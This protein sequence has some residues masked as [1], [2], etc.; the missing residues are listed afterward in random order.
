MYGYWGSPSEG[1]GPGGERG[2]VAWNP[3][4][5][6]LPMSSSSL[7][8]AKLKATHV[9]VSLFFNLWGG[10]GGSGISTECSY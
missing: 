10:G 6:P 9:G 3:W 1:P 8:L 2:S 5:V 4:F 7:M